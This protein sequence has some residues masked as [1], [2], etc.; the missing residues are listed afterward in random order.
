MAIFYTDVAAAQQNYVNFPGQ[1]GNQQIIS[2]PS[3]QNNPELENDT[4]IIGTYSVVGT[5]AAG[6]TINIGKLEAGVIVDP[7]GRVST[8]VAAPA[9]TLTVSI[10]DNDLG[11]PAL[12]PFAS[13][14]GLQGTGSLPYPMTAPLWV[15]G[16]AYVPGNVVQDP[17]ATTGSHTVNDTYTCISN[18]SG[19]TAPNAAAT[20]VWMPNRQRYSG[21]INPQPASSNVSFAGGTQMYGGPA[22]LLPYSVTPG[23]V[24]LGFSAASQIVAQQYQ[25]QNDCWLFA[26]LL[27]VA[28]PV[29]GTTIT[30]RVPVIAS[31]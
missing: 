27:T 10:G 11:N 14:A 15:T 9:T 1:P 17:T 21:S 26:R 23:Q 28:V 16:T 12:L 30:F 6:D 3:Q 4:E 22:S 29:A 13:P 5:E 8:G 19:A 25:I 2:P 18:T 31:N 20:T 7:N 24:T